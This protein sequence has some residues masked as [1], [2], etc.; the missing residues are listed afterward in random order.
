MEKYFGVE[1]L[2]KILDKTKVKYNFLQILLGLN[3]SE[4]QIQHLSSNVTIKYREGVRTKVTKGVSKTADGLQGNPANF[5]ELPISVPRFRNYTSLSAEWAYQIVPEGAGSGNSQ[6]KSAIVKNISKEQSDLLKLQSNTHELMLAQILQN[7]KID[8]EVEGQANFQLDFKAPTGYKEDIS[9]TEWAWDKS[10]SKLEWIRSKE[11]KLT[12][13]GYLANVII[14][15]VEAAQEFLNDEEIAKK[16]DNKNIELGKVKLQG[17]EVS[18]QRYIGRLEGKDIYV[19]EGTY[20]DGTEKYYI[21][22]KN[23]I[24]TSTSA[25]FMMHF[26]AIYD[27]AAVEKKKYIQKYFSK[28]WIPELSG[29]RY[30]LVE[31]DSTPS[32]EDA[33]SIYCAK[34]LPDSTTNPSTDTTLTVALGGESFVTD[35]TGTEITISTGVTRAQLDLALIEPNGGAYEIQN[36]GGTALTIDS[37][38]VA[39]TDKVEVTAEDGITTETYTITIA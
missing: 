35:I 23:F 14:L 30:L 28:S 24:M 31:T 12:K 10:K 37:T 9:A 27:M 29:A 11:S 18:G 22:P 17:L 13:Y 34:V 8:I 38:A 39:E 20:N 7:H 4:R 36:T 25:P 5:T 15:G 19:Y 33:A 1:Q 3:K 2:N 26:A 6:L 16:L 32:V 21:D